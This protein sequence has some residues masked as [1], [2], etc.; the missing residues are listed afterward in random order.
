LLNLFLGWR[1]SCHVQGGAAEQREAVRLGIR[2]QLFG[3][4]FGEDEGIDRVSRD[5]FVFD[6]GRGRK[7]RFA[8]RPPVASFGSDDGSFARPLG[9][10]RVGAPGLRGGLGR[11]GRGATTAYRP[12]P[13]RR[14]LLV[15]LLDRQEP[16]QGARACRVGVVDLGQATVGTLDVGLAGA[17][18][19]LERPVWIRQRTSSPS[20]TRSNSATASAPTRPCGS[21][22]TGR[23]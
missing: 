17:R 7:D 13:A 1:Q 23:W 2:S 6:C 14:Q 9:P 15:G 10:I 19:E 22:L 4:E 21:R 3:G 11:S 5:S 16:R 18:L 8:E 20:G 12:D